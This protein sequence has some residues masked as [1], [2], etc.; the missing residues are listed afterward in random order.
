MCRVSSNPHEAMQSKG[1]RHGQSEKDCKS[2]LTISKSALFLTI[3]AF[4]LS[5]L[6]LADPATGTLEA[7]A[8][9]SSDQQ[10]DNTTVE[11]DHPIS[12]RDA[13]EIAKIMISKFNP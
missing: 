10:A 9:S 3:T 2:Q 13:F 12:T 8:A 4:T 6:A 1:E 11:F 5:R 7:E